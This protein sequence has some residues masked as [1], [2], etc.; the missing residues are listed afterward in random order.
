M[1]KRATNLFIWKNANQSPS[2]A[3][4]LSFL[5]VYA[6]ECMS[7]NCCYAEMLYTSPRLTGMSK[8]A[9]GQ[10]AS[11]SPQRTVGVRGGHEDAG[12]RAL[13]HTKEWIT[14]LCGAGWL[15]DW[16]TDWCLDPL[17]PW[18]WLESTPRL[19]RHSTCVYLTGV[20]ADEPTHSLSQKSHMHIKWSFFV[21][22]IMQIN[23]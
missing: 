6:S 5:H 11:P 20:C 8:L 3:I 16:L 23:C 13:S 19:E 22:C 12:K 18:K 15:T 21:F 4:C 7:T 17:Q 14:S 1:Q 10:M 9:A 2:T